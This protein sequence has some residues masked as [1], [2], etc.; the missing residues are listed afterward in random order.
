MP[1]GLDTITKVRARLTAQLKDAQKDLRFHQQFKDYVGQVK[2][3]IA[4][5]EAAAVQGG[6]GNVAD[7]TAASDR[8]AARERERAERAQRDREGGRGRNRIRGRVDVEGDFSVRMEP[9]GR[10]N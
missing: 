6:W 8:R 4:A 7:A 3:A 10:R 1:D 2:D 5:K 9:R